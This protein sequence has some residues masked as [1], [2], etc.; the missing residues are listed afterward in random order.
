MRCTRNGVT[1]TAPRTARDPHS[2][3]HRPRRV[4]HRGQRRADDPVDVPRRAPSRPHAGLDCRHGLRPHGRALRMRLRSAGLPPRRLLPHRAHRETGTRGERP[5]PVHVPAGTLWG[6]A[7][8]V[9]ILGRNSRIALTAVVRV[10][11]NLSLYAFPVVMPLYLTDRTYGGARHALRLRRGP[12][13]DPAG[14]RLDSAVGDP[15]LPGGGRA[16]A[17]PAGDRVPSHHRNQ[18]PDDGGQQDPRLRPGRGEPH[19][20][21]PALQLD[22]GPRARGERRAPRADG[23]A[24][25]ARTSGCPPRA[26]RGVPAGPVVRGEPIVGVG[27]VPSLDDVTSERVNAVLDYIESESRG[28]SR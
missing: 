25:G 11:C 17:P 10:I 22:V 7:G 28:S 20:P 14:R 24:H 15:R 2:G 26:G 16:L 12:R 21:A 13:G 6:L 3:T 1:Q 27:Y 18:R 8:G 4:H 19:G 9:T 5:L 23:R